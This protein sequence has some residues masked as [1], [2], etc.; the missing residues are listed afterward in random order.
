M[1]NPAKHV[2]AVAMFVLC[3][4]GGGGGGGGSGSKGVCSPCSV[5]LDKVD[6]CLDRCDETCTTDANCDSCADGC[7]GCG[8]GLACA[9]CDSDCTGPED[10]MRCSVSDDVVA[11]SDGFY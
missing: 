9:P 7:D 5:D 2:A 3:A 1:R 11:C 10:R 4:C 8:R 6:D